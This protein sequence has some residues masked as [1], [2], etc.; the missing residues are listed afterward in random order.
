MD[1]DAHSNHARSMWEAERELTGLSD[2]QRVRA[3]MVLESLR[4]VRVTLQEIGLVT[5]AFG[6][7]EAIRYLIRDD[8]EK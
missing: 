8:D 5:A 6:V 7:T 2:R 1:G 4:R 3:S